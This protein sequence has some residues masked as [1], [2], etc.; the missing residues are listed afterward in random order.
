MS[1]GDIIGVDSPEQVDVKV[2][3]RAKFKA[4]MGELNG[5]VGLEILNR[6]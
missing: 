5:K 2:N 1:R 3:G 6:V 4:R